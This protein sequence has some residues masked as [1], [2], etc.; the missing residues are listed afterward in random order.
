MKRS[1][2]I[3]IGVVLVLV[4]VAVWIYVLSVGT[5]GNPDGEFG[6]LGLGD[7]T[8]D[9]FVAPQ[10]DPSGG[11]LV[12]VNNAERLR[13][14]TTRPVAGFTEI[15]ASSTAPIEVIYMEV[16]T[17]HIYSINLETGFEER[18]SATTIPS[19]HKVAFSHNGQFVMI[20]S[21]FGS[22][23]EF[24]LGEIDRNSSS[25]TN[26]ELNE[27][28]TSFSAT[29]DNRFLY[30]IQA[31]SSVIGKIFN[32]EAFTNETLFTLPF[33]EASI[34]WGSSAT[35]PH[36]VYPKT[37]RQ[38]ESF[39]YRIKNGAISRVAVDGYG[40]SAIGNDDFVLYSRQGGELYQ[41]YITDVQSGEQSLSPLVQI[42]EKCLMTDNA[43]PI[44]ICANT[45]YQDSN[46]LPDSWYK[47]E[48]SSS[49]NLWEISTEDGSAQL[50]VN[51]LEESG[52][53]LDI[54]QLMLSDDE[55][56]VYF[57]NQQDRTLWVYERIAT[58]F[59]AN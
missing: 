57:T 18:I 21:G 7:T 50:L 34:E 44:T 35:D 33:R 59:N 5:S 3:I 16:G 10:V 26:T 46:L 53:R 32:P 40:M 31:N 38:L 25:L 9:S 43:F 52:R 48:L 28:I 15:Q 56:N 45:Q 14:L 1:L 37:T 22:S 39:L 51:T 19:A 58:S 11:A 4:L 49:D 36:Y 6:N 41:T 17:G 13:Q 24:V 29:D 54:T 20:E 42:P 12:D 30:S 2:F 23:K 47:G 55:F 27:P 8:D